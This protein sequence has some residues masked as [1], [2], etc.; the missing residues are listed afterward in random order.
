MTDNLAVR[1]NI[2][3]VTLLVLGDG[4]ND[5]RSPCNSSVGGPVNVTNGNM[6][7]QQN[8]HSLPSTGPAININRTYNSNSQRTGHFGRGWSTT[9]D[10]SIRMYDNNLV[11]LNQS[12][13]RAIYLSRAVG[14]AGAFSPLEGDFHGQ[15]IQN[16]GGFTLM[17]KDGS[18]HQFNGAGKLLSMADRN[19][20]SSS[21][22]YDGNGFLSS[23]TN[24]F[25]STLTFTTN[26]NG[27]VLFL[28]DALGTIA[29]YTYGAGNV[30]LSVTYADNSGFQFSYDG[31][32]R[33]TSVTD[34]LG[35][36]VESHTYDGQ[37]RAVT[38][39]KQGGVEHYTLSY[40]S[41]N[42]TDVT[43]ALSHLTKY[44]FDTSRGRNVVTKVEGDCSCG[45]GSAQVRTWTYDNQLNVTSMTDALSHTTGY[46]YDGN[47][48]RLSETDSL[49]TANFTYNQFGDVLTATDKLGNLTSNTY[50]ANGNLL[51]TEDALHNASTLTYNARGQLLTATDARSQTTT[52]TF[53]A[54]TGNLTKTK[55]ALTQI[56]TYT[57]DVRNRVTRIQDPLGRS[58]YLAYDLAGRL[59]KITHADNTF[60]TFAYDLAGR[61]TRVTDERG[62][63]TNYAY[64]GA[65]RSTGTTDA[66]NQTT[67]Y[68]YDAMSNL[69]SMTDSL[70]RVTNY[71]YDD[72]NRLVKINYP[73]ATTGATRL[74][75]TFLYDADG[76]VT[77]RTDTAGRVTSYAYDNVNR[78]ASMTDANNKTTSVEYDAGSRV[79]ALTDA[80]NQ[81]YQFFYDAVGRQVQMTRVG[82]SMFYAYDG[83]GNRVQRTDYN[84]AVT[85]YGYDNINRVTTITYPTRVVTYSYNLANEITRAT[86]ENGSIY[87]GYDNRYRLNSVFDPFNYGITYNYDGVGNRT[88]LSLNYATYATYTYDATNRLTNLKDSANQSF[89]YN[90]D[91]VN[92]L[93]NRAAPNGVTTSY[94]YDGLD[95]LT[96]LTHA[97]GATTLINNQYQYNAANNIA[98]WVNASGN[99][100]YGYDPLDRLTSAANSA[101]PNES[102]AYDSVGNRASSH[103]SVSYNYQPFNKLTSTATAS[104]VYD[105]NGN[106]ISRTDGSGTT[107]FS[108]N[109]E[110]QLTQVT[111][112]TGVSV[113]YKYDALGRRIQRTTS[114]GASERYVYDGQDVLVDLNADWSV[115]TTYLNDLGIDNHLRQTSSATGVSYYL[116]DHLGSTAGLTDANGNL[117]EQL[118]YDSFG[119]SAGSTRTRYGYTGR[120]R[121]PDIGLLHY[122]ARSYDPQVGRFISED[123]AGFAGGINM[124]AY[125]SNSPQNATDPSGL[126]EIDVHY[127]LTYFLARKTGCFKEWE[128]H[129]IANEDQRTDED[130]DTRPGYGG[131]EQQRMQ[132]RVFHSLHPGA[133]EGVGS[134]LLWQGA[135]NESSGHQWIG[136]YLHYLQDTFSHAGYTDDVWGHSPLRGGNHSDDKTASDPAKAMRMAGA[137]W[138]AL[139]EYAKAKKCGCKP[140]WDNAWW[141]PINDFINVATDDPRWSTIDATERTLD[142]PG[143][144]DPAALAHKRRILG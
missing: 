112:P 90:Y 125:V 7:L 12:D 8:D 1:S 110:N 35:N 92:R 143:L 13:G 141:K 21:L 46:T 142:N 67:S 43:D 69:T 22:V 121:D 25:G 99:H 52:F 79:I 85:T 77:Q 73:P 75:E 96:G 101:Q 97:S 61:R 135:M 118:A 66:A 104:Y 58:T 68:S 136:R 37:G 23:V 26:A 63:P 71:D 131:T 45:S 39:E 91:T 18:A 27:Q 60:I 59:N 56:T 94:A 117:V 114:A 102:Y 78:L 98:S 119:N 122:R 62:N 15:V 138:K 76:N 53:S 95:R 115:A 2:A 139:V 32:N 65:Y 74:F 80:I 130:P 20:N 49:G 93:T 47:G 109:E 9:Y 106:L 70:A 120:E 86:N 128:A 33:L 137:T 38:S 55:D 84:G 140:K 34:A 50:D 108:W 129:E 100:A 11:R 29:N 48:N 103:L 24:P 87:L 42:E 88:K 123:P 16:G 19:G 132:N 83:V 40:V 5:G 6:Y 44:T 51:S 30:L 107:T 72:F 82:V 10:E 116:T 57:Y 4:E 54:T 133:A 81:R 31:A 134:A 126:Y 28:G 41:A 17:L 89:T 127:Y 14:S 124:F 111:R 144:G 113:N 64:D 3:T 36:V 105:N